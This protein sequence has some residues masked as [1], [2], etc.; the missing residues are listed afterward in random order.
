MEKKI[1]P[2]LPDSGSAEHR[3]RRKSSIFTDDTQ[4]LAAAFENPLSGKSKEELMSDVDLFVKQHGLTDF[5]DDFRKGALVAQSP[6]EMEHMPELS[7]EE[8]EIIQ[9]EHTHRWSHPFML[10][11]L[12]IMCSLAVSLYEH[13][14]GLHSFYQYDHRSHLD[15][16]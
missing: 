10:Y 5:R 7:A 11:W 12:C 2:D 4:N 13:V 9:R 1:S 15:L 6:S 14:L 3:D 16:C 8:K